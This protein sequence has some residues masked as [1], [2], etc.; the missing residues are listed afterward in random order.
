MVLARVRARAPAA[1]HT[2][3][4]PTVHRIDVLLALGADDRV[5][6]HLPLPATNYT[7]AVPTIGPDGT[8][9]LAYGDELLA[10]G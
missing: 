7:L 5:R 9:L 8:V 10:V 6:W 4:I 2:S 3:S 1:K